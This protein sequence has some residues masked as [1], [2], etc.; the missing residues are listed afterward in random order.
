MQWWAKEKTETASFEGGRKRVGR[1]IEH[2][3]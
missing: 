2:L 3:K 1:K